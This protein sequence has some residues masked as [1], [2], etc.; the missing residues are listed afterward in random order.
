MMSAG[1]RR[2]RA[3]LDT[4]CLVLM[5]KAGLKKPSLAFSSS[6][7]ALRRSDLWY[8]KLDQQV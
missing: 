1:D 5:A 2:H 4:V 3:V 7:W 8:S 6:P